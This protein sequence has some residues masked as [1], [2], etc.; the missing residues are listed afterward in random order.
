MNIISLQSKK[1]IITGAAS[2]IGRETAIVASR[3][4]AKVILLDLSE[5]GLKDT[6]SLLDG[7][8]HSFHAIDLTYTDS[9]SSL[10]KEIISEEGLIDG[11][12]H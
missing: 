1:I 8:G 6:F 2:G 7:N 3:Q 11:L 12:V 5:E 10:I 9:I 4:G